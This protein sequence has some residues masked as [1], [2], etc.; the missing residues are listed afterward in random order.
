MFIFTIMTAV[1]ESRD[2]QT[3]PE[4]LYRIVYMMN[5]KLKAYAH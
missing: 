2:S 5:D 3:S 1:L 4:R